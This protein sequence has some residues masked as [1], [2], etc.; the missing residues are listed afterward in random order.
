MYVFI[1]VCLLFIVVVIVYVDKN[2]IIH[3]YNIGEVNICL[4]NVHS[5][6]VMF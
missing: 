3:V 5:L 4:W 6:Q 2:N 1:V